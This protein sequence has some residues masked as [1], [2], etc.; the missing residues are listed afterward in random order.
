MLVV[1]V[2]QGSPS[3]PSSYIPRAKDFQCK[4]RE[5]KGKVK[6]GGAFL[7]ALM[8][9][10]ALE[11]SPPFLDILVGSGRAEPAVL[12]LEYFTR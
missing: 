1:G 12:L 4:T 3:I 7:P 5:A 10:S 9:H 11:G 6:N 8:V 2:G